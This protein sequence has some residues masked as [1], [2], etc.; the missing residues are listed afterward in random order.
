MTKQNKPPRITY[1]RDKTGFPVVC[2]VYSRVTPGTLHFA[3]SCHNPED[4]YSKKRAREIALGRFNKPTSSIFLCGTDT[5]FSDVLYDLI[6]GLAGHYVGMQ[7]HAELGNVSCRV[8]MAAAN[9]L[10]YIS[11]RRH[12]INTTDNAIESLVNEYTSTFDVMG[13]TPD[14]KAEL[15]RL[16]R[17]LVDKVIDL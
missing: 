16:A 11:K 5:P 7:P 13:G 15:R 10:D 8:K 12:R 3:L 6:R 9:Y 1:L 14:A 4:K 2:L 17:V